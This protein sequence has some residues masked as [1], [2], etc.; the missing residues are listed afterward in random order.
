[1]SGVGGES[2]V[3]GVARAA[4]FNGLDAANREMNRNQV[5]L[6]LEILS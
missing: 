6:D 5:D 3:A 2:R 4:G 1:M